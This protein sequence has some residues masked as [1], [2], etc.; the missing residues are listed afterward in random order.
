VFVVR[1]FL[2]FVL[3]APC[4]LPQVANSL[5]REIRE[6]GLDPDAC[7]RVRDVPITREDIRIFLNDGFLIFSKPVRGRRLSAVFFA[8]DTMGDGE[9]ML[10]PPT[11]VE[12]TSLAAFINSP[13]LNEH[14]KNAVIVFGDDTA[15]RLI[16][17]LALK[18]AREMGVE[19]A[20]RYDSVARNLRTSFELRLGE[21]ILNNAKS[22]GMLFLTSASQNVGTFDVLYEPN[23]MNQILAGQLGDKNGVVA[24]RVWTHFQAKNVR[25]GQAKPPLPPFTATAYRIDTTLNGEL[26]ADVKTEATVRIGSAPVQALSFEISGAMTI[27]SALIDGQPAE[28]LKRESLRGNAMLSS[29][30]EWFLV[31]APAPLAPGTEHTIHFQHEGQVIRS[32]GNKVFFVNA[33][34]S[35]YPRRGSEFATYD[36]SFRFPKEF[37]LVAAGETLEERLDGDARVLRKRTPPIRLAGFNLGNYEKTSLARNGLS[38]D[39]Y[40]NKQL[41][42]ALLPKPRQVILAPTSP[43]P[44]GPRRVEVITQPVPPPN[45]IARMRELGNDI[46]NGFEF[47]KS[48]LGAPAISALTVSPVSGAFGQGFPG[49]LYVSTLSYLEP[50]ERP[51]TARTPEMQTFFSDILPAHETAHQWFG[52]VVSSADYQDDWLMEAFA[53]YTALL[54][55]EK[56]R[57][58]KALD[59]TLESFRLHLLNKGSDNKPVD[60]VGPVTIGARLESMGRE[61]AWRTITYEKGSWI[62]HMLRRRMGDEQ[63]R[64][65]LREM[66]S[67]YRT[68]PVTT[69]DFRQFAAT[70][71]PPKS[72]DP[73]LENFFDQWVYGTGI[74]ELKVTYTMTGKAPALKLKGTLTQTGVPDDF[75]AD[76]PVEIFSGKQVQTVWVRSGS[77][78]VT[79]N[80][81]VKTAPTKVAI[82]SGVLSAKH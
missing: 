80:V 28:L 42:P 66:I 32:S 51:L 57:G 6:Q 52:N 77:D 37:T 21:A 16:D 47:M 50:A 29:G 20:Q 18:P 45:P 38:V 64:V 31:V 53:N 43:V 39:V 56:K 61:D 5:T 82:G 4:A 3:L 44:R 27:R 19:L 81:S 55:L 7:Y 41:E 65:L 68:Q 49:L 22:P 9:V 48:L 79:F 1:F 76:V 71:M 58:P 73:K 17:E 13:N 40:A 15:Q 70:L 34:S 11:R 25:S 10:L 62:L 14:F 72:P 8:D 2:L 23:S 67:R 46:L 74:P 33:R 75:T 63:F 26:N 54:Y 59:D 24:Y 60:S 12:R 69:E 30:N 36:L 35:W 78:P